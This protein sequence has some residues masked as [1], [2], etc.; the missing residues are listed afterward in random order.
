MKQIR[1][2][3]PQYRVSW[4]VESIIKSNAE[5]CKRFGINL[6]TAKLSLPCYPWFTKLH[7]KPYGGRSIAASRCCSTTIISKV[8]TACLGLVRQRQQGYYDAMYRNSGIQG[9]WLMRNSDEVAKVQS[10]VNRRG[11]VSSIKT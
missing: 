5:F 11:Q 1:K 9:Y 3:I 2:V 8:L 7:Q 4:S 10:K 6:A